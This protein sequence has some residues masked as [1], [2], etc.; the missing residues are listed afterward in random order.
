MPLGDVADPDEV[1][2]LGEVPSENLGR[3][4]DLRVERGGGQS[5]KGF[6]R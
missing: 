1:V 3:L 2:G 4:K 5:G 6:D